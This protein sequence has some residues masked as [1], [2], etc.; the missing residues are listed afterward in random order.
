M[1]AVIGKE[2]GETFDYNAAKSA[3]CHIFMPGFTAKTQPTSPSNS[4]GNKLGGFRAYIKLYTTGTNCS[5]KPMLK[6]E[7]HQLPIDDNGTYIGIIGEIQRRSDLVLLLH[8]M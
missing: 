5:F 4:F 3:P 6:P 8:S 2:V 1:K 7:L